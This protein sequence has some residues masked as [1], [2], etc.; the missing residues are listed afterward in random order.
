MS[1]WRTWWGCF[2]MSGVRGDDAGA[3]G[4]SGVAVKWFRYWECSL[5]DP[6]VQ[7]LSPHLFKLW[8]N[9]LCLASGSYPR[10][11]LPPT[12]EIA[13]RLRMN[14]DRVLTGV[15]EL[16]ARCLLDRLPDGVSVHNWAKWQPVSDDVTA[17]VRRYRRSRNVSE[18]GA[19][20][21]ADTDTDT[22]T[23]TEQKQKQKQK[24]KQSQNARARVGPAALAFGLYESTIGSLDAHVAQQIEEE[25]DDGWS[26]ECISHCFHE[27]S[28][29]NKRNWRY[30]GAIARRHR[31]E[32]CFSGKPSKPGGSD[33]EDR[34]A[35]AR[36]VQ[37]EVEA[38][39]ERAASSG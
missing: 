4:A 21:A 32:G 27:A 37:A 22:E 12:A 16:V 19:T 10:W 1:T 23:D 18:T 36:A 17:R 20:R 7:R 29:L 39:R 13:F 30:V 35:E 5:D 11:V 15:D 38:N 31:A 34:F 6:K 26:D 14:E 2:V 24:Q 25:I 33:P 3:A 8:V 28:E 9:L